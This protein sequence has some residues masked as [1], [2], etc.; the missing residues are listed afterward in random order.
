[1]AFLKTGDGGKLPSSVTLTYVGL[2]GFAG[3][4]N[5]PLVCVP[6]P[7]MAKDTNYTVT[8]NTFN[9]DGVGAVSSPS[10][11]VKHLNSVTIKGTSTMAYGHIFG[12]NTVKVTITF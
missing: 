8:I 2:V 6:F 12:T 5:T 10:V 3:D 7:F 1:M 4:T 9:I 11:H